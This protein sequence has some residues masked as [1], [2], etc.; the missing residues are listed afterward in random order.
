MLITESGLMLV[1]QPYDIAP[2][3]EGILSV[4]LSDE[5]IAATGA[6]LVWIKDFE[7]IESE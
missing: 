5:A 2:Y 1:Y 7:V 4:E 6:P 3:S